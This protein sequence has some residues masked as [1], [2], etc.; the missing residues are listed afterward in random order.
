[1]LI[2][3]TWRV[4][5]AGVVLLDWDDLMNDEPK[6]DGAFVAHRIIGLGAAGVRNIGRKNIS[7]TA[8][9]S[10]VR[11]F[12]DDDAARN[13]MRTHAEAR[14]TIEDY[15]EIQWLDQFA[16]D[17][18]VS[19][20][21]SGYKSRTENNHFIADY[22]LSSGVLLPNATVIVAGAGN[23]NIA[24]TPSP[25][26]G[27]Y[28]IGPTVGG[29]FTRTLSLLAGTAVN[30]LRD[31]YIALAAA[32]GPTIEIRNLTSGGTL[33]FTVTGS[34]AAPTNAYARCKWNGTAWTL[35]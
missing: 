13:F 24:A 31:F 35:V 21:L 8:S 18:L 2:T 33:L 20:I 17:T 30:D 32:T 14:P 16:G 3:S 22:E 11:V 29:V 19:C 12:D 27:V 25:F 5:L 4:T 34:S 9:F 26:L 23:T 15:G 28:A 7:H 1:M 10:R 6:L